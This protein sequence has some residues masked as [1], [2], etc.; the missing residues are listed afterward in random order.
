MHMSKSLLM[1]TDEFFELTGVPVNTQKDWRAKGSNKGPQ[2]AVIGG[3]IK[4]R[5]ADVMAWLDE[6]FDEPIKRQVMPIR[7][8]SPLGK[9]SLTN[10]AC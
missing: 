2:S 9:R 3:R 5:R 7:E 8:F 4:Y 10:A 1:G 6:Q